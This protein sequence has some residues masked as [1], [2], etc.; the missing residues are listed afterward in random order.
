MGHV[1]GTIIFGG[2]LGA[3]ARFIM[4]GEQNIGML[5]TIV[6]GV[7]GSVVGNVILH[8]AGYS[9]ANGGVAWIWWVVCTICSIIA[10]SVYL[11]ITNRK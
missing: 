6:L 4:K 11:G 7:I 9:N 3:L 10:I 2:I 1:I 8:F 5:W